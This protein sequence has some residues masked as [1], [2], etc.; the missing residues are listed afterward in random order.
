MSGSEDSA[1]KN[2]DIPSTTTTPTRTHTNSVTTLEQTPTRSK[3]SSFILTPTQQ[4]FQSV[5][6]DLKKAEK[7]LLQSRL[8]ESAQFKRIDVAKKLYT[9]R[10]SHTKSVITKINRLTQIK[11]LLQEKIKSEAA[12]DGSPETLGQRYASNAIAN[13]HRRSL[14]RKLDLDLE[15]AAA[16]KYAVA[17]LD[18]KFSESDS[19]NN[20]KDTAKDGTNLKSTGVTKDDLQDALTHNVLPAENEEDINDVLD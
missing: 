19:N 3:V 18:N 15:V 12:S 9:G 4:N 13:P 1:S 2:K 6:N 17:L 10:L 7:E 14:S 5:S 8:D 11:L 16:K 20:V